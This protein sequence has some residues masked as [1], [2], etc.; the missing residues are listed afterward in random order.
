MNLRPA[1]LLRDAGKGVA[2]TGRL[3]RAALRHPWGDESVTWRVWA[4]PVE[5][6]G[7]AVAGLS[8]VAFDNAT[9]LQA[10]LP[11]LALD[12]LVA[13][14]LFAW[15]GRRCERHWPDA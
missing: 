1:G 9:W 10:L 8:S 6:A 14:L 4:A 3:F 12:T 5:V 13:P 7:L 11:S 15:L 2:A